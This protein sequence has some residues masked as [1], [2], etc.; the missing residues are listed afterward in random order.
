MNMMEF[1]LSNG[2][3]MPAFGLGVFQLTPEQAEVSVKAALKDGYRLIDTANAYFNESAVGRAIKASGVP[4]EEIFL[5]TKL[6]PAVYGNKDAVDHTLRRLGVDY[7]D[8]LF[9][10]QPAGDYME[11]YRRLEE[12]YKQGKAKAIGIS[13]FYGRKL[14]DILDHAE[15]KPHVIQVEAHPYCTQKALMNELEP[16]GTRLMAWYPLGHGDKALLE[17]PVVKKIAA[18]HGVTPAQAILRWHTQMG[19][20]VIPGSKSPEHIRENIE[21]FKFELSAEEMSQMSTLDVDRRYYNPTPE[22]EEMYA[23]LFPDVDDQE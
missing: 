16:Y 2:V 10:H 13:N 12:A 4:R 19:F 20:C 1:E 6:W 3:R 14:R 8:L 5:S 17:E 18:S 15:I 7:V 9:I 21:I 22:Q 11:G 23:T